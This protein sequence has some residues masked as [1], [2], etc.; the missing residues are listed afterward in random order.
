MIANP[1]PVNPLGPS[2]VMGGHSK[3]AWRRTVT[4]CHG[5]YG[6]MLDPEGTAKNIAGIRELEGQHERPEGLGEIE[7][8]VTPLM[9]PG[10]E[11]L[12]TYDEMGVDRLVLL[13]PVQNVDESLAFIEQIQATMLS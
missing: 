8:T 11:M 2:V 13:A 6:F 1:R 10:V 12:E 9:R 4:H 3:P 7:I 5:W